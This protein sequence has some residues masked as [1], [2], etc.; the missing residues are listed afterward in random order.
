M[1]KEKS[2]KLYC[3]GSI[4]PLLYFINISIGIVS[5]LI[6]TILVMIILSQFFR[7]VIK[8]EKLV[9]KYFIRS[10]LWLGTL[11]IYL[12]SFYFFNSSILY[13]IS[14]L[15]LFILILVNFEISKKHKPYKVRKFYRIMFTMLLIFSF[16]IFVM[17]LPDIYSDINNK[18]KGTEERSFG[19]SQ[20][21]SN[22]LGNPMGCGGPYSWY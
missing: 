12:F 2:I 18:I 1:K 9:N 15:I 10:L 20:G 13:I 5:F 8:N 16:S 4:P 14:L 6:V 7:H 21:F 17:K 3:G 22:S 11:A 19:D